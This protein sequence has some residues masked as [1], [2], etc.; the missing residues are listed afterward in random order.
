MDNQFPQASGGAYARIH[1]FLEQNENTS[2]SDGDLFKFYGDIE[3]MPDDIYERVA[4]LDGMIDDHASAISLAEQALEIFS[5]SSPFKL[6][7]FALVERMDRF[8]FIAEP[9]AQIAREFND[10]HETEIVADDLEMVRR[11]LRNEGPTLGMCSRHSR[12]FRHVLIGALIERHSGKG[13]LCELTSSHLKRFE[14]IRKMESDGKLDLIDLY[15][16]AKHLAELG[17]MPRQLTANKVKSIMGCDAVKADVL[18]RAY[19]L[20]PFAPNV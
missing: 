20:L 17:T 16:L 14:H 5:Y 4:N 13:T 18:Y 10:A 6:H 19:N 15:G 2:L 7:V 1:E 8:G 9:I 12:E 11:K 3:E